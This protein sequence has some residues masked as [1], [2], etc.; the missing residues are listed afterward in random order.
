MGA[1]GG[2]SIY[3]HDLG[4]VWRKVVNFMPCLLYPKGKDPRHPLDKRLGCPRIGVD[5]VVEI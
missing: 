4:I 3:I 5:D 1:Y 2:V